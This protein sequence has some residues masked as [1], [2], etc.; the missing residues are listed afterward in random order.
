MI[1]T[2]QM[3]EVMR[4]GLQKVFDEAFAQQQV[5]RAYAEM[6]DNMFMVGHASVNG[7]ETNAPPQVAVP[8]SA[9]LALGAAAVVVR[10]PVVERRRLFA[11][12]GGGA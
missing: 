8:V 6:L 2:Q 7:A 12:F 1:N 4:P 5:S 3:V 9:A 10:N 11:W